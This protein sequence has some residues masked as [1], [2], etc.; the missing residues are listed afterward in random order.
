MISSTTTSNQ[1]FHQQISRDPTTSYMNQEQFD[2]TFQFQ[3]PPKIASKRKKQVGI[4][5]VPQSIAYAILTGVD[6]VY[7]LYTS[8]FGVILYMIFGTSKY[9]SIGSFAIISLMTGVSCRE[10][11]DSIE[12][13]FIAAEIRYVD[14]AHHKHIN[15]DFNNLTDAVQK[16][17][18]SHEELV[19]LVTLTS[20]II[21]IIMALL[22]VEFMASYLSD[23]LVS[24]FCT[25]AAV[26]VVAVQVNKLLQVEVAKTSGPGYLIKYLFDFFNNL[27]TTNT[28][29]MTISLCSFIFLYI[30]KDIIS[31]KLK[32]KLPAPI[33]FELLLVIISTFV[34]FW[35]SF[36]TTQNIDIVKHVPIGLPVA[37]L[38]RLDLISYV[39]GPSFEIAFVVVALHLSMCKV[40]NRKL[41]SSTDINQEL[42][43][44]G[45][46]ASL[47]SFFNSYPISSSLGRSMI[48]VECVVLN[49]MEG[50][51]VSVIFAL[52]TTVFRIQW[53]RWRILSQLSGTEEYRDVGR[54]GRVSEIDGVKIFRFDA[55][56]LFINV[57][58]FSRSIDKAIKE[59]TDQNQLTT[60]H[61]FTLGP[62]PK[63]AIKKQSPKK[64]FVARIF[65]SGKESYQQAGDRRSGGIEYLVI[66]CSA[67]IRDT[68]EVCGFYETVPKSNFFPTIH[69]AVLAA[70][71]QR[72]SRTLS[73]AVDSPKKDKHFF[74]DDFPTSQTSITLPLSPHNL[75][76]EIRPD[77]IDSRKNL[78][79]HDDV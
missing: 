33:P 12:R 8:F 6:P 32:K 53:P 35:F 13:D 25:G 7:G 67:P 73:A 50:L 23:Q 22:R 71:F 42:Y 17:Q 51:A 4:V 60:L 64:S 63:S 72:R 68:L 66:D 39:I 10:I 57:E 14:Q 65:A 62:I 40:F 77:H 74:I 52:L 31:Q 79:A 1:N 15:V 43:A 36:S 11:Y 38:P 9:V 29:A 3:P 26:H 75:Q 21:Q 49:V 19:Q 20:G 44:L 54:Y 78:N 27:P 34:S 2:R 24:G 45:I 48:N 58:H 69:D 76:I 61:Q 16:I 55:P 30:G 70:C 28:A 46:V 41:A 47:S 37:K 59:C 18:V 5:H 56:L